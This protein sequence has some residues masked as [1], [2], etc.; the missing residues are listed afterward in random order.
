M[1]IERKFT[2][3][4]LPEQLESYPKKE[5]EQGYLCKKPIIRVRRMKKNGKESYILCYKSKL[6]LEQKE[7]GLANVCEEVE[8]RLTREAY[9]TLLSKAEGRII[10]KTRYLIPYGA[11]TIELDVFGG[12]YFGLRFAEVEFPSE[13]EANAFLPPDWFD[14]DVTFDRRFRN[15]HLAMGEN[16]PEELRVDGY[17]EER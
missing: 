9:E 7:D 8:L 14:R 3:K 11:Y 1:E 2:I 4:R 6:G 17:L 15:N 13:E 16:A 5:L 10:T 12:V